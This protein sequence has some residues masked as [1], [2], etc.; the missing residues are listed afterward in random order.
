MIIFRWRFESAATRDHLVDPLKTRNYSSPPSPCPSPSPSSL[1]PP[2]WHKRLC[3]RLSNAYSH[4][5]QTNPFFNGF[6]LVQI[7]KPRVSND[8]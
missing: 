4:Y 3:T 6:Q 7:S 5:I 8:R 2:L 1:P